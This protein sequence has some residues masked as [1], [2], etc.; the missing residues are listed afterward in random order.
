MSSVQ[1][2][3]TLGMTPEQYRAKCKLPHDYPMVAANYAATRSALAKKSG[4][5][6]LR[7]GGNASKMESASKSKPSRGRPRKAKTRQSELE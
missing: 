5:G 1:H 7:V 2:L 6:Q 4:L 3:M